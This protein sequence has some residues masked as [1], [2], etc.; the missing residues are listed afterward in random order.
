MDVF[1]LL[2]FAVLGLI[3]G[4]FLNVVI[5]RFNSTK[6]LGGRS[7][8][9][10]CSRPLLW[11]DLIPVFSYV[12][13]RGRCR[14]CKTRISMQYPLVEFATAFLF[15]GL[16]WKFNLFFFID[17]FHFSFLF[18]YY[19]AAFS[20]L[21]VITVY[22]IRHKIIPDRLSLIFGVLALVGLFFIKGSFVFLHWPQV[23]DIVSGLIVSVPFALMWLIS[24][25]RWMGLGDAK[26]AIGLGLLLGVS[27]M[28]FA[29]MLAFWFGALIGLAL[30]GFRKLSG[31]KSEIPFAPFLVAGTII[32][33][34]FGTSINLFF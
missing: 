11:Y 27:N 8:C 19:A 31:L 18:T 25:G 12:F 6:S 33:F 29:T 7:Q 34:F 16:Y 32:A 5:F 30:V 13:L 17:L 28:L 15:A 3:I 1:F 14:G 10:T 20:L 21:L 23:S 2:F 24:S 22:D 26:L 4:S 9:L